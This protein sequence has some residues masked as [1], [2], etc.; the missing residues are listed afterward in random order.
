MLDGR[1]RLQRHRLVI[2]QQLQG[3]STMSQLL[4]GEVL[5]ETPPPAV[6]P[7]GEDVLA[8]SKPP[9]EVGAKP[10]FLV[11]DAEGKECGKYPP[12][13]NVEIINPQQNADELSPILQPPPP[14][15]KNQVLPIGRVCNASRKHVQRPQSVL[16]LRSKV[17]DLMGQLVCDGFAEKGHQQE[18]LHGI[19]SG[20]SVQ[21]TLVVILF[22]ED[23]SGASRWQDRLR[24]R[25]RSLMDVR[26]DGNP[27]IMCL[28]QQGTGQSR[29][30]PRRSGRGDGSPGPRSRWCYRWSLG[31]YA[32][33]GVGAGA[34]Q[35]A[36]CCNTGQ[37]RLDV[38]GEPGIDTDSSSHPSMSKKCRL[39]GETASILGGPVP[40]SGP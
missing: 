10:V 12:P 29:S 2:Q 1:S 33:P 24:L 36:T 3:G 8:R 19:Q 20:R 31:L 5:F 26:R 32:G 23:V 28:R 15:T 25:W 34:A 22:F 14:S 6:K 38:L 7:H 11:K 9:Q 35:P 40:G 4:G 27:S 17:V 13:T 30:I 39:G 21:T 37:R 16:L 18:I